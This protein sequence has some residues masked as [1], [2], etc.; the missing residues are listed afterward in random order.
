MI[1]IR[2]PLWSSLRPVPVYVYVYV[3]Y[4]WCTSCLLFLVWYNVVLLHIN[5]LDLF[6]IAYETASILCMYI[7]LTCM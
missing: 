4:L 3:Y 6:S 1:W 5:Y 2:G 7:I